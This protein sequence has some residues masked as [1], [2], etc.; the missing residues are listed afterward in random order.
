MNGAAP[1]K[2]ILFIGPAPIG[3]TILTTGVL[4]QLRANHPDAQFT[5]ALS[6]ATIGLFRGFPGLERLI[7]LK[8]QKNGLHWWHLWRATMATHWTLSVDM[9]GSAM[10]RFLRS[11]LRY[12]RKGGVVD[13]VRAADDAA[14]VIG[15]DKSPPLAIH[16]D[17][18]AKAAIADLLPNDGRALLV[19]APGSNW[20]PKRWPADRFGALAMRLTQA[21]AAL[22]QARIIVLGGPG[23]EEMTRSVAGELPDRD[24]INLGGTLPLLEAAALFERSQLFVGNDSGLMHLAAAAGAPTLGL[25]GPTDERR[26]APF[27]PRAAWVR[28]ERPFAASLAR[29]RANHVDDSLLDDL[30]VERAEHAALAVLAGPL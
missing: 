8:K 23:E 18:A 10:T 16:T 17:P 9:R 29:Y 28:G 5:L 19:L 14:Q 30:S 22:A 21:G 2:P 13:G 12:I 1:T 3:D 7:P 25:F 26:Y 6:P 11:S 4:E 27:G 15:L 24:V 20:G